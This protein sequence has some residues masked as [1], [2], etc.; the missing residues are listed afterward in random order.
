MGFFY[1]AVSQDDTMR[2]RAH[3]AFILA[4]VLALAG[5][6]ENCSAETDTKALDIKAIGEIIGIKSWV[7]ERNKTKTEKLNKVIKIFWQQID[8][9]WPG[10]TVLERRELDSY[11]NEYIASAQ[12][13]D[14]DD[15]I[16]RLWEESLGKQLSSSEASSLRAFYESPLGEKLIKSTAFAN[17]AVAEHLS[18]TSDRR[19]NDANKRLLEAAARIQEKYLSRTTAND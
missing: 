3:F 12:D 11:V 8:S 7:D 4:A 5:L 2:N 14:S 10:I 19:M 1:T 17:M 9:S 16:S 6:S 15:Q 13:G 18:A